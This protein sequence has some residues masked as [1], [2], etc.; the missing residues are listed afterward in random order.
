MHEAQPVQNNIRFLSNVK[1][2]DSTS[3]DKVIVRYECGGQQKEI[4]ADDVIVAMSPT[5]AGK[6]N[7]KVSAVLCNRFTI[8]ASIESRSTTV[9][10][11]KNGYHYQSEL[12]VPSPLVEK[13]SEREVLW[14]SPYLLQARSTDKLSYI[15]YYSSDLEL[16]WLMDVSS[17]DGVVY[18]LMCFIVANKARALMGKS[19]EEIAALCVKA[20]Q[21]AL[22]NDV[23]P[24]NY[25]KVFVETWNS[26][27]PFSFGGPGNIIPTCQ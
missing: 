7:Y 26:E 18:G 19:D 3:P 4:E 17:K 8:P 5:M 27:T 13:Q 12:C 23:D 2:I 10:P 16:V 21:E 6:L 9:A 25:V 11:S 24:Q 14:T 22:A 15:G 20:L 1:E